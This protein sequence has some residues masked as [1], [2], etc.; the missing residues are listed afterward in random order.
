[1]ASFIGCDDRATQIAREA[2]SRQAQQNT[3]MAGVTREAAAGASRLVEEESLSRQ[4][5]LALQKQL[6]DEGRRIDE[7]RDGLEQERRQIAGARRTESWLLALLQGGGGVAA[8][9]LSLGVAWLALHGLGTQD[10]AP[11]LACEQLIENLAAETSTP[12]SDADEST[13][14]PNELSGSAPAKLLTGVGG[15]STRPG[16]G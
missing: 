15:A 10:H 16:S 9:I 14:A 11:E 7:A 4:Q 6:Q 8:A 1:L 2:A 13:A 3:D 5:T 12:V